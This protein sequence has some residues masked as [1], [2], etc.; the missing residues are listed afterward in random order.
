M[1]E[2]ARGTWQKMEKWN[3]K[4]RVT[5]WRSP[6]AGYSILGSLDVLWLG[7]RY[8]PFRVSPRD[9]RLGLKVDSNVGANSQALVPV[10]SQHRLYL[11]QVLYCSGRY[12]RCQI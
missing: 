7:A 6:F 10:P 8:D 5:F 1:E 3:R 9:L 11:W 2:Q 4:L 12:L